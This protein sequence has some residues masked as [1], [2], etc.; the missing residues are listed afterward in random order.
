MCKAVID[1]L[2]ETFHQSDCP[3]MTTGTFPSAKKHGDKIGRHKPLPYCK[4]GRSYSHKHTCCQTK[5]H[6][7]KLSAKFD[8]FGT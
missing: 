4:V 5:H 7:D 6:S 8:P 3:F 2:L 1:T